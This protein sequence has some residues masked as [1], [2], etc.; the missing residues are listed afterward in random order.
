MRKRRQFSDNRYALALQGRASVEVAHKLR[1][2][3]LGA[4]DCAFH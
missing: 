3:G 4:F 1:R 2:K